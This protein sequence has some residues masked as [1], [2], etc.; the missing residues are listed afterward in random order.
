[1]ILLALMV[2]LAGTGLIVSAHPSLIMLGICLHIIVLMLATM[3]DNCDQNK[4]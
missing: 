1:M 3:E 4:K 2:F